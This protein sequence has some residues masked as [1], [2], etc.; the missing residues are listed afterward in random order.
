MD[1]LKKVK[2]FRTNS[3]SNNNTYHYRKRASSY[4]LDEKNNLYKII[5][6]Y[7]F[8]N[9]TYALQSSIEFFD[10]KDYIIKT[11]KTFV[12]NPIFSMDFEYKFTTFELIFSYI[13][14][15]LFTLL[16][17]YISSFILLNTFINPGVLLFSLFLLYK[18]YFF[19]D[20]RRFIKKEKKK[21][22]EIKLLLNNENK[23]DLCQLYQLKWILGKN[24]YWIEIH[25][26]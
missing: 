25:K 2:T 15:V 18:I 12:A 19:L 4:S 14:N 3:S 9:K 1:S 24:G 17:I 5:I 20:E 22:N 13:P 11:L 7:N 16:F 6:P 26:L 10:G 8:T 21:I 23:S